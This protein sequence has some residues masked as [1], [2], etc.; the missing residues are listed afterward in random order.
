MSRGANA[1]N[2]NQGSNW[3]HRPTRLRIYERDG[4]RCVWCG[5]RVAEYTDPRRQRQH[6]ALACL[7]HFK[8]RALGG[9]N[10]ASNLLTS[11]VAC[12]R[13]RGETSAV[14]YALGVASQTKAMQILERVFHA[15]TTA[16]PPK[17]AA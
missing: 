7:D 4:W 2:R 8:P 13:W 11:C 17:K 14:R 10:E 6:L 12:N 9:T 1:G 16:L 3:A 5:C 15:V